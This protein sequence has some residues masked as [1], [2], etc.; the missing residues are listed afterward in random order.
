MFKFW[1]RL[2]GLR[3]GNFGFIA[4]NQS[5]FQQTFWSPNR[6][7]FFGRKLTQSANWWLCPRRSFQK[8]MYGNDHVPQVSGVCIILEQSW[9]CIIGATRSNSLNRYILLL[10]ISLWYV[11]FLYLHAMCKFFPKA[12]CSN[13]CLLSKC[14]LFICAVSKYENQ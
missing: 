12:V 13:I 2:L 8:L 11:G 9:N 6:S 4:A 1:K 10:L 5:S 14:D 3:R 7:N